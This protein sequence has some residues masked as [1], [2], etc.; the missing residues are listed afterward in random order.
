MASPMG[1]DSS[2]V[3]GMSRHGIAFQDVAA[4]DYIKRV[5]PVSNKN[6]L[7]YVRFKSP[8]VVR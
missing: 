8:M 6:E 3:N 1:R 7:R 2:V 4:P 5:V